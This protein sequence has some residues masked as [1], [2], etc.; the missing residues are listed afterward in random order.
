MIIFAILC[1]HLLKVDRKNEAI[2][3]IQLL[4]KKNKPR[5]FSMS[6]SCIIDFMLQGD[7]V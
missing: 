4:K 6:S 1:L 5:N 3:V 7:Y 2:K